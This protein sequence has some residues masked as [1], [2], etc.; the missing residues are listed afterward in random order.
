MTIGVPRL[1]AA[2]E[3]PG[4]ARSAVAIDERSLG[5]KARKR[6]SIEPAARPGSGSDVFLRPFPD[7]TSVVTA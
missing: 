3:A 2:L 6:R 5:R 1:L 7:S 4:H